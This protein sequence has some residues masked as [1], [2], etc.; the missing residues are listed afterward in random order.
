MSRL[1]SVDG[2]ISPADEACIPVTDEGLLRPLARRA[3][4][5]CRAPEDDETALDGAV[6]LRCPRQE[7]NLE[8]SD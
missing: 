5:A 4:R 1:A 3:S 7:S 6:S 2:V 8:P